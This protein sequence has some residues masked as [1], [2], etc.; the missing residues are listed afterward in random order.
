MLTTLAY[1]VADFC[2]AEFMDAVRPGHL[3]LEVK[4]LA[5]LS[6]FRREPKRKMTH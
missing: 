3:C 6:W 4:Y 1:F 2:S 5:K